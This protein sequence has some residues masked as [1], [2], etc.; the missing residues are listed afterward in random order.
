MEFQASPSSDAGKSKDLDE[1]QWYISFEQ[2]LANIA[3]EEILVSFFEKSV[4]VAEAI[5]SIRK[6]PTLN[7]PGPGLSSPAATP[8]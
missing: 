1:K 5:S 8:T 6:F 3:N 7:S 2:F 4:D